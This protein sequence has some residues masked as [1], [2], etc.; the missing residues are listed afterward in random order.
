MTK[1]KESVSVIGAKEASQE[2]RR[3][4]LLTIPAEVKY[5]EISLTYSGIPTR[6]RD[7]QSYG[8]YIA[9]LREKGIIPLS[10]VKLQYNRALR[11]FIPERMADP[12][13]QIY[14]RN[15]DALV[16]QAG[17]E[18]LFSGGKIHEIEAKSSSWEFECLR[19]NTLKRA[20]DA[21]YNV[22][23]ADLWLSTVHF[24]GYNEGT[25]R[26]GGIYINRGGMVGE[27]LKP[28]R[29]IEMNL[30]G[31]ETGIVELIEWFK[32]L[33]RKHMAEVYEK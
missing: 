29:G 20:F 18:G 23:E 14:E 17:L 12:F 8:E 1:V 13:L 28:V 24:T 15:Q 11:L 21:G 3:E 4:I 10:R 16:Q 27:S 33:A 6:K 2:F 31:V 26:V 25:D 9:T 5:S 30:D 7:N 32:N 19:D 22:Q